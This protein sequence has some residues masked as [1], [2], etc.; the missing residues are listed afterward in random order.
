MPTL[1]HAFGCLY[2]D[3]LIIRSK[4]SFIIH[5]CLY[6]I[7]IKPQARVV[8]Y[9]GSPASA[10]LT[11]QLIVG[12]NISHPNSVLRYYYTDLVRINS[13]GLNHDNQ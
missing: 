4:W 5:T 11:A 12:Q 3:I 13:V 8:I 7:Y 2:E 10:I 1:V 9:S 6:L